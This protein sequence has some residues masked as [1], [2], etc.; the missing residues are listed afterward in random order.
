MWCHAKERRDAESERLAAVLDPDGAFSMRGARLVDTGAQQ[1]PKPPASS[2]EAPV[3][4]VAERTPSSTQSQGVKSPGA[5]TAAAGSTASGSGHT[6]DHASARQGEGAAPKVSSDGLV[7]ADFANLV[8]NDY[9]PPELRPASK[10]KLE[11]TDFPEIVQG[12]SGK[13]ISIGGFMIAVDFNKGEVE[14]FLLGRYPP[15]CCFGAVPLF[16]EWIAVDNE[17]AKG[18]E[19][20]PYEMITVT[21][22]FEAGEELD[23]DGFVE[24]I[25]RMDAETVKSLW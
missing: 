25:Y 2:V 16:D 22:L 11:L 17:R 10:P 24:S 15:G 4:P 18:E 5:G 7:Y 13:D 23:E 12:I 21:G 20:S 9:D 8:F 3:I 1:T 19:F 14:R 6:G